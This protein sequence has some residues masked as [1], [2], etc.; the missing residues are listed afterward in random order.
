MTETKKKTNKKL[1]IEEL[2][3]NKNF[4]PP[5]EKSLETIFEEPRK[6]KNGTD[7]L[8]S[9]KKYRR[10]LHFDPT[11]V[12]IQKRKLKA[13]KCICKMKTGKLKT[14]STKNAKKKECDDI[15]MY[16]LKA[17][18]DL[19]DNEIEQDGDDAKGICTVSVS[20]GPISEANSQPPETAND[21]ESMKTEDCANDLDSKKIED[22][23]NDSR[24]ESSSDAVPEETGSNDSSRSSCIM[25]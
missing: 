6:A 17:I 13:K 19:S 2:Y 1:T 7:I 18:G 21:R 4:V 9:V 20:N 12:K 14:R 16:I 23:A 22:C 5:K 8:T 25:A 11:Q 10:Y 24:T 15:S 3:Q